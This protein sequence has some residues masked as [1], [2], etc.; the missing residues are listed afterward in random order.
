MHSD[1]VV[2]LGNLGKISNMVF[3][4]V[5][6]TDGMLGLDFWRIFWPL[7][8]TIRCCET[9]AMNGQKK[10]FFAFLPLEA[11]RHVKSAF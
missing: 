8:N 11:R 9:D 3:V 4:K 6:L 1:K 5:T 10:T 7:G 2:C